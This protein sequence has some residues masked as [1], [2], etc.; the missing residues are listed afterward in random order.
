MEFDLEK[1]NKALLVRLRGRLDAASTSVVRAKFNDFAAA[2]EP[3]L[4]VDMSGVEFV[5]SSGL[6]LLVSLYRK[7]KEVE[8]DVALCAV[9]G[10]ARSVLELTRIDR[11]FRIYDS[12]TAA[13]Q[14]SG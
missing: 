6:G 13:I 2:P 8:A 11:V 10:P 14:A 7:R 1:H 5:D 4:V 12:D 3:M 9:S